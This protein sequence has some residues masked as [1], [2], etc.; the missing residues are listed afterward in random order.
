MSVRHLVGKLPTFSSSIFE[1]GGGGE[2]LDFVEA[3]GTV[4]GASTKT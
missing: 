4:L 3:N 1:G 2:V